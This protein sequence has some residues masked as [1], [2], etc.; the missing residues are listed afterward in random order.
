MEENRSF[1]RETGRTGTILGLKWDT[2]MGGGSVNDLP[3]IGTTQSSLLCS[4]GS[5]PVYFRQRAR[6]DFDYVFYRT[7]YVCILELFLGKS[8]DA[9][10]VC[11]DFQ[12]ESALEGSLSSVEGSWYLEPVMLEGKPYTYA[13]HHE[14]LLHSCNGIA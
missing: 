6:F 10:G 2:P 13:R 12:M 1:Y 8:A 7:Y 5:D 14:R 11:F 4:S 9:K 3:Y